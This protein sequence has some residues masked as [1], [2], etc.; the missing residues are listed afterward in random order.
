[1]AETVIV[2][3]SLAPPGN[4]TLPHDRFDFHDYHRAEDK[5][6]LLADVGDKATGVCCSGA[7]GVLDADLMDRMPNLK[8]ISVL[9]VGYNTVDVAAAKERGIMVTNTPGVLTDCVADIGMALMLAIS[10]GVVEG[11]RYTR[12]GDWIAHGMMTYTTK[13]TGKRLGIVGFGRIGQAVAKRAAGFDMTVA[14]QGPN[15]KPDLPNSYYAD[16]VELAANVDFL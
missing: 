12:S 15:E 1:M 14:Y 7:D 4:D 16:P 11:D 9:G 10:R 5:E 8:M 2:T 13:V 6:A 3:S